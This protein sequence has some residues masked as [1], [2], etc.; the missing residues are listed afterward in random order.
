MHKKKERTESTMVNMKRA[1]EGV[2][3]IAEAPPCKAK[4]GR[5]KDEL[6]YIDVAFS[7]A[8]S[9]PP[10]LHALQCQLGGIDLT[11]GHGVA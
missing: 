1:S 3:S 2:G 7:N 6:E 9:S 11:R 4:R 5:A 10:L 8:P